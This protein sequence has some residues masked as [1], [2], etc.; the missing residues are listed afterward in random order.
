MALVAGLAV[1][2]CMT[3]VLASLAEDVVHGDPLTVL[4]ARFSNWLHI[5]ATPALTMLFASITTLGSTL[6]AS[7]IAV[8]L[9]AYLLWRR[10]RYWFTAIML[11][12]FGGML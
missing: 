4:D 7:T 2:I 3:L 5:N 12:I 11:S 10:Q 6:V 9:C 1:F 8:I